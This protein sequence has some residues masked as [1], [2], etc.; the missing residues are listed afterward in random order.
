MSDGW[1]PFVTRRPGPAWKVGY[2]SVGEMGPKR[3]E[4][5]HSAEGWWGGIYSVLDGPAPKSWQFTIGLD[6]SEQ[7]Y[8]FRTHCW[9]A[10][11]TDDDGAVAANF[12]FVGK[13]HLG[14]AGQP[15]NEYQMDMSTRITTWC[16]EQ[17]DRDTFRRFDGWDP[18]ESGL[19]LLAEHNEVSDLWSACPSGRIWWEEFLRRLSMVSQEE[20]DKFVAQM[21]T[22]QDFQNL[23]IVNQKKR[24]DFLAAVAVNYGGRIKTLESHHE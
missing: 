10:G 1:C 18:D 24:I 23:I 4:V 11:D 6:R 13:E 16:A 12:D 19:W 17:E 14:V 5:D 21:K 3:G 8:D 15:L 22:Q 20:F 2:S 7:H 9:H